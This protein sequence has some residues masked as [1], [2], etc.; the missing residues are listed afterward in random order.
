MIKEKVC[1]LLINHNHFPVKQDKQLSQ[2]LQE[3][4]KIILLCLRKEEARAKK[5]KRM[6][7]FK[8]CVYIG[9][10]IIGTTKEINPLKTCLDV[11][12]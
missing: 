10:Y 7:K 11:L 1:A 2:F 8:M 5:R 3:I 6:L 12:P 4:I 9:T